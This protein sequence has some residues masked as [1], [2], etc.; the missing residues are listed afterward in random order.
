MATS[1]WNKVQLY[2]SF[3]ITIS[4]FIKVHHTRP[5]HDLLSI[6]GPKDYKFSKNIANTNK[7][8]KLLGKVPQ[9]VHNPLF[10]SKIP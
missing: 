1:Y 3:F 4:K 6:Q 8:N 2:C 10:S 5:I 9:S 7:N